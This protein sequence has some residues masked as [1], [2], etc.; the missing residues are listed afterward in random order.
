MGSRVGCES[1]A[2]GLGGRLLARHAG[3]AGRGRRGG[4][5][6]VTRQSVSHYTKRQIPKLGN[7]RDSG[8]Y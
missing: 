7:E 3:Q 4:G 5:G 8:Q 2:A 1:S 6:C